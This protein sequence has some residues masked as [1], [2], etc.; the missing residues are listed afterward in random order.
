MLQFW[1]QEPTDATPGARGGQPLG[2]VLP[3]KLTGDVGHSIAQRKHFLH[4]SQNNCTERR[5]IIS[6]TT[7]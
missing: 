2:T 4:L 3:V 7:L 6:H 1:V 5:W